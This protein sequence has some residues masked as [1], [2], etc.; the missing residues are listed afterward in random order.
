MAVP[1]SQSPPAWLHLSLSQCM[2]SSTEG[3]GASSNFIKDFSNNSRNCEVSGE[4]HGWS[5]VTGLAP[6]VC[7][8]IRCLGPG[9][10][11]LQRPNGFPLGLQSLQERPN[12]ETDNGG[13]VSSTPPTPIA[14]FALGGAQT[15]SLAVKASSSRAEGEAHRLLP[16]LHH[17][18]GCRVGVFRTVF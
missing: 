2:S 9:L 4:G 3:T 13:W 8:Q 17:P 14:A 10:S 16:E 5:E 7:R 15:R 18:S 6:E 12:D 11:S 1:G